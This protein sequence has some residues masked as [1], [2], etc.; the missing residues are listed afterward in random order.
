M[1]ALC[2]AVCTPAEAV[3]CED[4]LSCE[5]GRTGYTCRECPGVVLVPVV[6]SKRG[7]GYLV[8]GAPLIFPGVW[9]LTMLVAIRQDHRYDN[10]S[11][12]MPHNSFLRFVNSFGLSKTAL[13]CGVHEAVLWGGHEC[14]TGYLSRAFGKC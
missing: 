8:V 14:G 12:S 7:V 5:R 9:P 11:R 4:G 1:F 13:S 2:H 6:F 3:F 10:K